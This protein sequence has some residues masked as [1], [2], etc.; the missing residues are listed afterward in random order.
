MKLREK[1]T[2]GQSI[3]KQAMRG[4]TWLGEWGDDNMSESYHVYYSYKC[5]EEER[6][7]NE[8][9]TIHKIIS[10]NMRTS[11]KLIEKDG[12]NGDLVNYSRL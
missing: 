6:M 1:L 7:E 5:R 4:G 2:Y 11:Q 8:V 9:L 10:N 3:V 12:E